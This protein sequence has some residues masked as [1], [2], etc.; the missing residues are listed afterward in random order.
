MQVVNY[1]ETLDFDKVMPYKLDRIG[2]CICLDGTRTL[3]TMALIKPYADRPDT[4]GLLYYNDAQ[5]L[6][7]IRK[8]N[9]HNMQCSLH[10]AGTRAI[11]QYI[12]LLN[13]VIRELGQKHLRHRIEHFSYPTEEQ[14][15]MAA[16]LE[17]A[18]PMQ[19]I[20]TQVWDSG[21]DSMYK[22][23][24]GA[25]EAGKV[26]PIADIIRA[27]GMV[28]GGS[29]SPVTMIDPL[30]GIDA[31]VNTD[32][33][34]RKITMREALKLYT[35]NGAWAAH[36]DKEKGT[37]AYGKNADLVVLERSPFSDPGHVKEIQVEKTFVNGKLVYQGPNQ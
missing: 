37:L 19:P 29:D 8:A 12:Y 1:W 32:N 28:C 9:D 36:E 13:Q 23:R 21:E 11:D 16:E 4:R 34:H 27:G 22:K 31:C 33:P 6:E 20:F 24:F 7:F 30:A 15:Q 18:L 14:I 3:H 17:L 2:G 35:T 26:E 25:A 5:I 10:A